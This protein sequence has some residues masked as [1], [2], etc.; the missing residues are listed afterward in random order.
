VFLKKKDSESPVP[1]PQEES[2]LEKVIIKK[3]SEDTTITQT[4]FYKSSSDVS[5]SPAFVITPSPSPEP[6]ENT[7]SHNEIIALANDSNTTIEAV[8]YYPG[9]RIFEKYD[10]I[11]QD[12][13]NA[14]FELSGCDVQKKNI[15]LSI[16]M[17]LV[18]K[19]ELNNG[20]HASI[21]F[22]PL[23]IYVAS[24]NKTIEP[25]KFTRGIN[26]LWAA[27]FFIQSQSSVIYNKKTKH[28]ILR[29]RSSI[30]LDDF[31]DSLTRDWNDIT[32]YFNTLIK[33]NKYLDNYP[34][35]RA[36]TL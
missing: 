21:M 9:N 15:P 34:V 18:V 22:L 14:L 23:L 24:K 7:Y 6:S 17:S 13:I 36:L 32:P 20:Q 28:V 8:N 3:Q 35:C 10:Y 11:L 29:G 5:P 16:I 2:L 4:S 27:I 25:D 26:D 33:S 12:A 30:S 1:S 31:R 19:T